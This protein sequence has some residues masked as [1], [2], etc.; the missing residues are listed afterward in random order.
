MRI[1][2]PSGKQIHPLLI[3]PSIFIRSILFDFSAS[4][5]LC[6]HEWLVEGAVPRYPSG[7]LFQFQQAQC[8]LAVPVDNI[9]R[10][11]RNKCIRFL[12]FRRVGVYRFNLGPQANSTS[13]DAWS[14]KSM[15]RANRNPP[16]PSKLPPAAVS[17]FS[18]CSCASNRPRPKQVMPKTSM[19]VMTAKRKLKVL[20]ANATQQ[21]TSS[22]SM[23]MVS[24]PRSE[25]RQSRPLQTKA[26]AGLK[27]ISV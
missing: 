1:H 13:R 17:A 7:L 3:T 26:A 12:A 4:T 16:A 10:E 2:V 21:G 15:R 5:Y 9:V 6:E 11:P 25:P 27:R 24:T 14:D 19:A 22:R 18:Y 20:R 8:G 23:P